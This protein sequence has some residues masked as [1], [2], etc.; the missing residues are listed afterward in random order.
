MFPFDNSK[1][2]PGVVNVFFNDI[3]TPDLPLKILKE[4]AYEEIKM[5]LSEKIK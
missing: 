4:T 3:L 5:S 1:G 2:Y